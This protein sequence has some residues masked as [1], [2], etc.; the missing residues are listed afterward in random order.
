M[1]TKDLLS[2][3]YLGATDAIVQIRE[4]VGDPHSGSGGRAWAFTLAG[5]L[6]FEVLP[7]RGLDIGATWFAGQ[8]VA[9]RAAF[10]NPG[11]T[12]STT[13]WIGRFGG[14]LLVTCGLENIGVARG[15]LSQHGTHHDTRAHDVAVR[16]ITDSDGN[17]G[18]EISGTIDSLQIFGRRVRLHRTITSFVDDP[19]IHIADRIVNEGAWDAS[20]AMLYH[21]NFGAPLVLPGTRVEVDA[22]K[23]EIREPSDAAD[24]WTTYPDVV[25]RPIEA[26]WVHR[27]LAAVDGCA[28]AR[29]IS[30][31][32]TTAEV[33]W[34]AAELPE[35]VQWVFPARD[36]WALG[37]EPANAPMWGPVRDA[38]GA[39]M[40]VLA[41]G[42]EFTAN[43]TIRLSSAAAS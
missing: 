2:V 3:G 13:E 43:I 24:D 31:A 5:G 26:V 10:G 35:L 14:G 18:V 33:S 41:P 1:N 32:G 25:D 29:V 6:V 21:I 20:V 38:E 40:R 11:P 42:E 17:P 36:S 27:G 19:A 8:P 15:D 23:H 4:Q 7:E 34:D 22:S 37:I 12:T 16:R 39:G 9:W 28:S 30:P